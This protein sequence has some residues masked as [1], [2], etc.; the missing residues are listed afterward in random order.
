M[1]KIR[2]NDAQNTSLRP[3]QQEPPRPVRQAAPQ[4]PARAPMYDQDHDHAYE[5]RVKAHKNRRTDRVLTLAMVVCGIVF[6]VCA[7]VLGKRLW[8]DHKNQQRMAELSALANSAEAPDGTPQQDASGEPSNAARFEQLRSQNPDFL[9]WISIEDT[10]LDLP[11]M[12]APH[13]KDFYLRHDFDRA[14]SLYGTPYLEETTT[15]GANR[16]SENL[17][18]YGH[19]MKTG[20]IFGCLTKYA[21]EAFLRDHPIVTF[22]TVYGDADYEVFAAFAI[23]VVQDQS[24]VYNTYVDLDEERYNAYVDEVLSRSVIDTG[25]RPQYGEQLLTLSTCEYSTE[26]GRFVVVARRMA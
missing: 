7:G 2:R 5:Q 8:E 13:N 24:F 12:Y 17:V 23:D 3:A 4:R 6:L 21:D 18:I 1:A 20:V 22:D 10:E 9:G 19:N 25:I 11:V 14:Y 16:E 26:N 15:F